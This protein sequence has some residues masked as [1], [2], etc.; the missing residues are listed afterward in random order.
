MGQFEK[1]WTRND[2]TMNVIKLLEGSDPL[3][4]AAELNERFPGKVQNIHIIATQSLDQRRN[5]GD[6]VNCQT[7]FLD[8]LL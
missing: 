4:A 8:H 2:I 7:M 1:I 6:T 3:I 5:A